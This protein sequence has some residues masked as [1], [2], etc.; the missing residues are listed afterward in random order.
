MFVKSE[1]YTNLVERDGDE[2]EKTKKVNEVTWRYIATVLDR[3]FFVLYVVLTIILA[4][5]L[6]SP[7]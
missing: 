4:V 2:E 1:D 5:V 7:R 6:A 3:F